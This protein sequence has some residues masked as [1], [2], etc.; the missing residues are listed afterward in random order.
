MQTHRRAEGQTDMTTLIVDFQ[1]F[2][3]ARKINAENCTLNVSL[4][5]VTLYIACKLNLAAFFAC[6]L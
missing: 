1:N 3:N 5:V 2:A 6:T 4:K